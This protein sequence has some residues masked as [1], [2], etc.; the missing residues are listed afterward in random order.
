MIN[1]KF[2]ISG[3]I[4]NDFHMNAYLYLQSNQKNQYQLHQLS[5]QAIWELVMLLVCNIP[6]GG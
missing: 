6:V 3:Y 5:F 4:L 2:K 1:R